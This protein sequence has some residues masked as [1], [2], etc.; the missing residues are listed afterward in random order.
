[1]D[2]ATPTWPKLN[3]WDFP[4]GY[5]HNYTHWDALSI[6]GV[7]TTENAVPRKAPSLHGRWVLNQQYDRR[8]ERIARG[9]ILRKKQRTLMCVGVPSINGLAADTG[10]HAHSTTV[11]QAAVQQRNV[12]INVRTPICC[13]Y[14]TRWC[15]TRDIFATVS[16]KGANIS[17][18][19]CAVETRLKNM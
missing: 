18:G 5:T 7:T 14:Y 8:S 16:Q 10:G 15:K 13:V 4:Y 19:S 3:T 9:H 1:M 17:R 6:L 11:V 12:L 2:E